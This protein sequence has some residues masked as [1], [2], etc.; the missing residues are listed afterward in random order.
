MLEKVKAVLNVMITFILL[1]FIA[2]SLYRLAA[3]FLQ[4]YGWS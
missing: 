2:S 4:S 3:Y 1:A